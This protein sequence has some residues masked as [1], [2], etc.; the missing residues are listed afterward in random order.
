VNSLFGRYFAAVIGFGFVAVWA[1]VGAVAALLCLIGSAVFFAASAILQRRR[2]DE[3]TRSF[4]ER[5]QTLQGRPQRER[6][7][8]RRGR[9]L[10][11]SPRH[12][13]VVYDAAS[14]D[15]QPPAAATQYGW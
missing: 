9:Q 13:E 5:S 3:F 1:G 6:N 4:A 11:A 8:T 10:P 2:V 7:R 12:V 14:E 15:E